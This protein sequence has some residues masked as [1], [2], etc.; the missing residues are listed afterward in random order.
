MKEKRKDSVETRQR[1]LKAAT[2]IFETS[3]QERMLIPIALSL[4]FGI[5]FA[6][7]ITLILV[8]S[9]YLIVED[10]PDIFTRPVESADIGNMIGHEGA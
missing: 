9:V 6:T 2:K 7:T 3:G 4:A 1:L 10:M 8:P 5:L